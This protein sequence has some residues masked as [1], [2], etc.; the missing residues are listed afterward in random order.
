[1]QQETD[2]AAA[3]GSTHP[4]FQDVQEKQATAANY[5]SSVRL[6]NENHQDRNNE[7]SSRSS[8]EPIFDLIGKGEI[9]M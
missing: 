5:L 7:A 6:N 4:R 9:V 3:V 1:M 2:Q 8:V